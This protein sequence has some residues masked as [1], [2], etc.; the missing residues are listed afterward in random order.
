MLAM[1]QRLEVDWVKVLVVRRGEL[2]AEL[3]R[4]TKRRATV[5]VAERGREMR[6][7]CG[8][9]GLRLCWMLGSFLCLE[10]WFG[11]RWDK[12]DEKNGENRQMSGGAWL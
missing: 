9:K 7:A 10:N 1:I 8:E 3:C 4:V 5:P 11:C 2:A 6:V 12:R